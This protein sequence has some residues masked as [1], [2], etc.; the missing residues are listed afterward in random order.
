MEPRKKILIIEDD[1]DLSLLLSNMLNK[2]G[3]ETVCTE[4]GTAGLTLAEKMRPDLILLDLEIAGTQGLSV[5]EKLRETEENKNTHVIIF[6]NS[7]NVANLSDAIEHNVVHYLPKSDWE[8][9]GV[10]AKVK[11]ALSLS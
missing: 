9:E 10:L 4:S 5:L 7:A 1:K 3:F 6:S 2:E 8:L 11:E